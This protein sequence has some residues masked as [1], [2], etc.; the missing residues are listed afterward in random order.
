[1]AS[2]IVQCNMIFA[3]HKMAQNAQNF[4]RISRRTATPASRWPIRRRSTEAFCDGHTQA[5]GFFGGLPAE[6]GFVFL[7]EVTRGRWALVR[8]NLS[9]IHIS[10]PT[11]QAE[12]SYAV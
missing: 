9:L 12:I 8:T 11:R 3:L 10:E 6:R 2:I 7:S 4:A 5:F 1:M